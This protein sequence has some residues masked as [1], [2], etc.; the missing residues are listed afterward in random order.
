MPQDSSVETCWAN[1]KGAVHSLC[2]Q[3]VPLKTR[4]VGPLKP[5][6]FDKEY[7]R[8]S[9]QRRR[10]WNVFLLSG[11][12]DDYEA[13][14][15]QR[16][17]CNSTKTRK[18]R[19]FEEQLAC[20]AKT[21]PKRIFAYVKRRLKSAGNVPVLV[22][23]NG[24]PLSSNTERASALAAHFASVFATNQTSA[25]SSAVAAPTE[26]TDLI[27][28]VAEVH[29]LVSCLDST[30]PAGPD[31]L[32]PL[33]LKSLSAVI[34]PAVTDL[35]NRS[36]SI[37]CVP[38]DWKCAVVKPIPKGGDT[39]KVE[40][41]RPI[42]LTAVL[43]K[44]LEKIVKKRLLQ[45][46]EINSLLTPAQHGFVR[47]RSCITNLL[48]TWHEWLQAVNQ[49]KSVDVV[50]VD[51]SKAF[52]R[53]NHEILLQKLRECGVG[54][55]LHQW[56]RD[57]LVG[58]KWRV[59]VDSHLTDWY[60][61]TSGVPQGTVLGPILFLIHINDVPNLLRS[62]CALFADDLKL[63]RVI[64][65]SDDF[66]ILQQDLDRLSMWSAEVSLPINSAKSLL[67]CLGKGGAGRSYTLDG[68]VLHPAHC[69]RDLGVIQR[70][71]M[72]SLDNTDNT[73]RTAL[74]SLWA[75]KRS[76]CTWSKEIATRLF[77]SI[78][79]PVLEY[80]SPAYCPLTKGEIHKLERVQ[81]IATRLIPGLQG[82]P[83]EERCRQLGLYTL[84]YRRVR[85]D[86][87][88]THR[89]LHLGAYPMLRPLLHVRASSSTRGHQYKLVVPDLKDIICQVISESLFLKILPED[90]LV[91]LDKF[92]KLSEKAQFLSIRIFGRV[93]VIFR[94]NDL[95][96]LAGNELDIS[97]HEVV[98]LGLLSSDL[99]SI[100]HECLI[101]C[102][103]RSELEQ[104]AAKYNIKDYKKL[105]MAQLV[106]VLLKK[107]SVSP[108]GLFVGKPIEP[109]SHFKRQIT[110][111]LGTCWSPKVSR[112]RLLAGTIWLASIGSDT[113]SSGPLRVKSVEAYL[114]TELYNMLLVRRGELIY[115]AYEI[116]RCT[117]IYRSSED[118]Q[119]YL[120]L[121]DT[122]LRL[123]YMLNSKDYVSAAAELERLKPHLVDLVTNPK[124]RRYDVPS[125]LRR[126]TAPYRALRILYTGVDLLERRRLYSQAVALILSILQLQ[127]VV[128]ASSTCPLD[129]LGPCRVSRLLMRL[130]IDQ[131]NHLKQPLSALK[132]VQQ[133]LYR[134]ACDCSKAMVCCGL[135]SGLRLSLQEQINKLLESVQ[136]S[137]QNSLGVLDESTQKPKRR[138]TNNDLPVLLS[139]H[140]SLAE[141]PLL[142]ACLAD[143]LMQ[144]TEPR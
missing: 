120:E 16:N 5:H 125:F 33:I 83:Y 22:G 121:L 129:E 20:S 48:L 136:S 61:S 88:M 56:I 24:Q 77:T 10:L 107:A 65:T 54:G 86:L 55:S 25:P 13:Y 60:P 76:F 122:E 72:K 29:G 68:Q 15:R 53:V 9:R 78:V 98:T 12:A 64:H 135:R 3:F 47:G 21:A 116:H 67:L 62:P 126:Y 79:R 111:I 4:K 69:V 36:L 93:Q 134:D 19:Q 104:L 73:Y 30:K 34:S 141:S 109:E 6:W 127:T 41:Y 37:G 131:G 143:T 137:E 117:Q 139:N 85:V 99:S 108:L 115:P 87:I 110:R 2:A 49:R 74:R 1:I 71:D 40:N 52:D 23:S 101:G 133:F 42:C 58:R 32:H 17:L 27:C 28:N 140:F 11:S 124:Y 123:D 44:V 70:Y 50:Y 89:V 106:D 114:K 97:L 35:F 81:H 142:N 43:S 91:F 113:S 132:M 82:V 92:T 38:C 14:K 51:F 31:G 94:R 90:E 75:L 57:F 7:N 59:Q 46:L 96:K 112:M 130:L 119:E 39:R 66:D 103:T 8:L 128:T 118:L 100:D 45:L 80:G 95:E 26:L 63:W 144:A 18:R 105:R 84:A 102:L 138:R